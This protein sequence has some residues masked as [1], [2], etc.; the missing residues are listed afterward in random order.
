[1]LIKKFLK[2]SG[3]MNTTAINAKLGNVENKISRTGGLITIHNTLSIIPLSV[4]QKLKKLRTKNLMLVLYS[5]N[6]IITLKHQTL[7]ITNLRVK[8][9]IR[10]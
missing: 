10:S 1:M 7:I 8:H 3:L 5:R 2:V 4:I 6:H 9:L